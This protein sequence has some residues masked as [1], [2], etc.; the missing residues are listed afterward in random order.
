MLNR[1]KKEPGQ[2]P[3][4]QKATQQYKKAKHK[5]LQ[6]IIKQVKSKLKR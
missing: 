3:N 1:Y 6:L 4:K 5:K 2:K